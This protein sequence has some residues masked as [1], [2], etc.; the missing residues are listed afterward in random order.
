MRDVP[1]VVP[2]NLFEGQFAIS[3]IDPVPDHLVRKQSADFNKRAHE[4]FFKKLKGEKYRLG[5]LSDLLV[6]EPFAEIYVGWSPAGI[7]LLL[8]VNQ[9]FQDAFFPSVQRGDGLELFIDTRDLKSAK[10]IHRFCHHFVFLPKPCDEVS[11]I[12]VTRFRGED[13]HELCKSDDLTCMSEFGR[14]RYVM[15]IFIPEYALMGY[16]PSQIQKLGL[17]LL[18]HRKGDEPLHYLASTTE[19]HV[20][21]LPSLWP[22]FKL[23]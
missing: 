12:E 1:A 9:G 22:S 13:T 7:A 10:V 23:L 20:Q 8:E 21:R 17:G 4:A 3:K 15:Q 11:A 5:H 6:E 16:D 2:Y 19:F 18:L 14:D